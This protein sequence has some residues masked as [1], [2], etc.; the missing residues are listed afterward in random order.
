MARQPV[1][2]GLQMT[3]LSQELRTLKRP[4]GL[5]QQSNPAV[6]DGAI[7]RHSVTPGQMST[8]A[9]APKHFILEITVFVCGA[10][11]MVFEIIGSRILSPF[12]GTST[13]IWTSL[14]GVILASLSL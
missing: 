6:N 12:I 7:Q 11:L 8:Q 10:L 2:T 4:T 9:K 5:C 1:S 3:G 13:Y 14:I